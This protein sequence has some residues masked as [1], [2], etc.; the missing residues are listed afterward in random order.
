MAINNSSKENG[1]STWDSRT[2]LFISYFEFE[3][4]KCRTINMD[5]TPYDLRDLTN[6]LNERHK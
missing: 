5:V 1:R 2:C 4:R 3:F 6:P